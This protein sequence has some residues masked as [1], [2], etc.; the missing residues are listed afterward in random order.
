M[1]TNVFL[2]LFVIGASFGALGGACAYLITFKEW[3][4]HYPTP[5]IP[6]KMALE[7]ALF[8]FIFFVAIAC[9]IGLLFRP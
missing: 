9:L 3:Q 5:E 6:R 7:T 1:Q 2:L 8:T 4:H